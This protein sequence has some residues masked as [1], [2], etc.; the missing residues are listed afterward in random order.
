MMT[1]SS[2]K[3]CSIIILVLAGCSAYSEVAYRFAAPI[4]PTEDCVKKAL[5]A[6]NAHEIIDKVHPAEK[7]WS[8]FTGSA[9]TPA[10][11][12][13]AFEIDGF[14]ARLDIT[15]RSEGGVTVEIQRLWLGQ[16]QSAEAV[17]ETEWSFR[18]VREQLGQYCTVLQKI[19][20]IFRFKR[21]S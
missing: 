21:E 10:F 9:A 8:I 5:R 1:G 17:E 19:T 2:R 7:Y 13:Y 11:H 3:Q 14:N 12:R 15:D 4:A 18:R 16:A 20:G 6:A